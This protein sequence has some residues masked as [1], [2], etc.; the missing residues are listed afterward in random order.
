MGLA[1]I[2]GGGGGTTS[3][4]RKPRS[5]AVGGGFFT[6]AW[7]LQASAEAACRLAQAWHL[8]ATQGD[9]FLFLL[10]D[11]DAAGLDGRRDALSDNDITACL[12]WLA[13]FHAQF[14]GADGTTRG[15]GLWPV[16]TYWHLET[17]PDE[18]ADGRHIP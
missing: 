2:P 7:A 10:E 1:A 15:D 8:E 9:R 6:G 11:L 13:A 12:A 4:A 3:H 16:G 5:Y 14:L 18:V 17:R